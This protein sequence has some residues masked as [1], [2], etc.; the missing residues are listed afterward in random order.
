MD[1]RIYTPEELEL[2][3]QELSSFDGGDHV[4]YTGQDD[5]ILTIEGDIQNFAA[6]GD[7]NMQFTFTL[8]NA[9]TATRTALL[10]AGYLKGNATLAA[11]QMTDGAFND[12]GGNAGLTGSSNE[13]KTIEE[14]KAYLEHTPHRVIGLKVSSTTTANINNTL[15]V[16]ELSPFRQLQ[17]KAIRPQM[18]QDQNVQQLGI[19]QMP[20]NTQFD[21]YHKFSYPVLA[22]SAVTVT[23]F[24]G[25]GVNLGKVLSRRAAIGQTNVAILGRNQV[26]QESIQKPRMIGG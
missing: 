16:Q 7:E 19:I 2:A 12:T 14:L 3:A 15:T 22:S 23:L 11:G 6:E 20:V 5:D 24:F 26:L 25:A 1:N 9:A 8:T 21:N 18:Y 4:A 13:D 17:S 10:W